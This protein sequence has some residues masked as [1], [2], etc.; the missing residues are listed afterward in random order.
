MTAPDCPPGPW[1]YHM[2]GC[3]DLECPGHPAYR[4]KE[5]YDRANP[6]GGVANVFLTAADRI[7]AGEPCDAVMKDLGLMWE[8]S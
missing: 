8:K 4:G 3:K 1:C 7:Q 5:E 6:L 2:P